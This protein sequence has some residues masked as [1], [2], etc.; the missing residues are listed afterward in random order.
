MNAKDSATIKEEAAATIG[1]IQTELRALKDDV[2]RLT[3][4]IGE[5]LAA[6]RDQAAQG[7]KAQV[8]RARATV[9]NALA[10]AGGKGREAADA[11]RE[12][13]DNISNALEES[14]QQRPLTTLALAAGLGFIFGATWRR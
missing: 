6:N 8:R 14:V 3:Q 9:D 13:T 11:V 10:D 12:V 4:Q 1:N 7:V 5:L 2:L